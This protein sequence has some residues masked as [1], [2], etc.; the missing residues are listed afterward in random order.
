MAEAKR[1][2]TFSEFLDWAAYYQLRPFGDDWERTAIQTCYFVN[3]FSKKKLRPWDIVPGAQDREL[4]RRRG[5]AE[6]LKRFKEQR[7]NQ[8]GH[9]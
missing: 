8:N 4:I 1:T 7:Q 6:K 9:D 5:L 2:V 3:L